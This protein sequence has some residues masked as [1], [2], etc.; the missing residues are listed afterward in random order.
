MQKSV[1]LEI[2]GHI[3]KHKPKILTS[4]HDV[5]HQFQDLPYPPQVKMKQDTIEEC[6]IICQ[7]GIK[8]Q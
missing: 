3:H 7:L 4:I 2:H 8:E 5:F 1:Y 6:L